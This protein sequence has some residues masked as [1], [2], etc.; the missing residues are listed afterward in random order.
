MRNLL[1][2]V[3]LRNALRLAEEEA[4]RLNHPYIGTEHLL[5]GMVRDGNGVAARVL[6]IMGVEL[7]KVRA[8]VEFI[9]GRG[10]LPFEGKIPYTPRAKKVM[11]LAMDEARRLDHLYIGTEHLLLGLVREG[12]GIAAGVLETLGVN[13]EKVRQKVLGVIG[14]PLESNNAFTESEMVSLMEV[15]NA[16]PLFD[17][18][19]LEHELIP[20]PDL[21]RVHQHFKVD[22][23]NKALQKDW[24]LEAAKGRVEVIARSH[25][26]AVGR[27]PD[28][29]TVFAMARGFVP[30]SS[31]VSECVF[32]SSILNGVAQVPR[33]PVESEAEE[34]VPE[35]VAPSVETTVP[36]EP[37]APQEV[38]RRRRKKVEEGDSS[39]NT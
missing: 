14:T 33:T 11:Q 39:S 34:P 10:D 30:F 24:V 19:L 26:E 17:I 32:C 2:T 7:P 22:L 9:I 4:R 12:E 37:P 35:Q 8:A 15:V 36:S 29:S 6:D 21:I 23:V 3:R 27:C 28:L 5:L 31:H 1:F 13:L 25:Y 16:I 20:L 38:K 18:L